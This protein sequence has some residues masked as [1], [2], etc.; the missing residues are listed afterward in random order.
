MLSN[1]ISL[2][3]PVFNQVL[4]NYDSTRN[5]FKLATMLPFPSHII[6]FK[7]KNPP[8]VE[9]CWQ[10]KIPRIRFC[11]FGL[12]Q[13]PAKIWHWIV[14]FIYVTQD[15]YYVQKD[16]NYHIIPFEWNNKM[17]IKKHD[18]LRSKWLS[19]V[20]FITTLFSHICRYTKNKSWRRCRFYFRGRTQC[21]WIFD[22]E[23]EYN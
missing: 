1:V 3:N 16:R 20:F 11:F 19:T 8:A 7:I 6:C 18:E 12:T 22:F 10:K 14:K 17:R 15:N 2:K 23:T 5:T 13:T 21:W 9:L 4:F